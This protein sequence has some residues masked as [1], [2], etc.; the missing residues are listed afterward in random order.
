MS[1]HSK[2]KK[3]TKFVVIIM[4][5]L[6]II[7][8]ILGVYLKNKNTSDFEE[9]VMRTVEDEK[10]VIKCNSA[11]NR[12]VEFT[13][14]NNILSSVKICEQFENKQE[15]ENRKKNY[16]ETEKVDL[17]NANEEQLSLEIEKKDFGSDTGKSY[18][19]MYDKYI[20]KII[21][22]YVVI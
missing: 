11:Y 16:E 5:A 1:K 9:N 22:E 14:E 21:G 15:Y 2:D 10:L 12:I 20:N 4:I 7:I 3:N 19:Y 17:I 18:D 13:F 8:A 6:I